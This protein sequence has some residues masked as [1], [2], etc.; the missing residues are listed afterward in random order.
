MLYLEATTESCSWNIFKGSSLPS[1]HNWYLQIVT[2]IKSSNYSSIFELLRLILVVP[3]T[4]LLSQQ[5]SWL[6]L[7]RSAK[8]CLVLQCIRVVVCN[9]TFFS[10]SYGYFWELLIEIP[11]KICLQETF[12][13]NYHYYHFYYRT[14]IHYWKKKGFTYLRKKIL[15]KKAH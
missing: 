3:A 13:I 14:F 8:P 11:Q 4:Y 1:I 9:T 15:L 10:K 12:N 6:V 7:Y 2:C 5:F